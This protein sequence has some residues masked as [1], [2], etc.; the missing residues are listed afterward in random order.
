MISVPVAKQDCVKDCS[1]AFP[2]NASADRDIA[3]AAT[4]RF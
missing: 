2:A 4:V 1:K 3:C